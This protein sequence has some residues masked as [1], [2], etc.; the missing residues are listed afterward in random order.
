M[1][2]NSI[3]VT[4][5]TQSISSERDEIPAGE[6]IAQQL[7]NEL[8]AAGFQEVTVDDWRDMG[9]TIDLRYG[10]VKLNISFAATN[11]GAYQWALCCSDSV[12]LWAKLAARPGAIELMRLATTVDRMFHADSQYYQIRWHLFGWQSIGD[13]PW[14]DTLHSDDP[15]LVNQRH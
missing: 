9:Y 13:E 8:S 6:P 12:N 15:R 14:I 11:N 1:Q 5:K 3:F 2:R 7:A 4:F 10:K